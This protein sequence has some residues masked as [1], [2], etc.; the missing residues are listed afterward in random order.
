MPA[1]EWNVV[2]SN[3]A[4]CVVKTKWGR[5]RLY[6]DHELLDTTNDLYASEDEA[7][8]VGV[9]GKDDKFR[10]EVFVKPSGPSKAAIRVNGEW[11]LGGQASA[12]A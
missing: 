7:T 1:N 6:V 4:I 2:Y 9:F 11:I 12:V 3:H 10:I 5:A 8:L